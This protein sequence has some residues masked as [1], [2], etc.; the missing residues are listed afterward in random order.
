M[1]LRWRFGEPSARLSEVLARGGVVLFPTESS[2]GVGVDPRSAAG[3]ETVCRLKRRERGKPLGVVVADVAQAIELGVS[4]DDPALRWAAAHW[5]AP[6][7]VLV[8]V[9]PRL[10]AMAGAAELAVR[11][12]D[13]AELRVLLREVGPLTATSANRAGG[14]PILDPEEAARWAARVDHVVIEGGVLRGG[15]P[16]TVV[17]WVVPPGGVGRPSVLRQGRFQWPPIR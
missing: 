10:P 9:V 4:D 8:R 12:P 17:S 1:S 7:S 2:Y 15:D 3:V 6:L 16:S 11:V 13:H 14:P 5:P